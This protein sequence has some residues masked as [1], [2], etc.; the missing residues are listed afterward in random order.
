M[1]RKTAKTSTLDIQGTSVA[2]VSSPQG[3]YLSLT[4]MLRAKDGDFFIS[5]WLRNRNTVEFLGI[6]ESIYNPAFNYGEFA[7][8]KSQAGLNSYK[9]SIKE[10]VEKT[11]AIGLKATAGR[12]GGTYAHPDIAFE[13]GMWISPE[14]KIYLVK[15]FRRLTDEESKRLQLGW[16]LQRTLSKINYRIHTDAIKETLIPSAIT[17]AQATLVYANE[18]DLLNV[19]LFGHTAK[20]WRDAHPDAEGNIRDHALL[21]Q[22]VVLTNL[23]SLNS[24]L[25]RQG[26]TPP[27]RLLKLNEVAIIQMRTLLSDANVK[28]LK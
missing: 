27:E 22:L 19:A 9:I 13:F 20:Q 3:D 24:V 17:K 4:D 15:E 26:L 6:W 7:I 1:N 28:R 23:E 10:W 16:N 5:D 11:G 25:V 12:Y 2:V 21:E 14:F 18:A 8:I